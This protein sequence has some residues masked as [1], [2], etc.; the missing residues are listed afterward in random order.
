MKIFLLCG[1]LNEKSFSDL[2]WCFNVVTR[3]R[4]IMYMAPF[5][6]VDANNIGKLK[7]N[8]WQLKAGLLKEYSMNSS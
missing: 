7:Q 5:A 1:T 3:R 4:S 2:Y 8:Y 6:D